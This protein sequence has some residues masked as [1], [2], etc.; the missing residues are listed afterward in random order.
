MSVI[1]NSIDITC[2]TIKNVG[3]K[4]NDIQYE[5]MFNLKETYKNSNELVSKKFR[6]S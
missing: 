2:I 4:I 6:T 1:D 5:D 3:S